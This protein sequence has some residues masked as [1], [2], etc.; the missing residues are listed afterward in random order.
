MNARALVSWACLHV[1]TSPQYSFG[2]GAG[3]G[4]P[5]RPLHPITNNLL[6][7]MFED[8]AEEVTSAGVI[9]FCLLRAALNL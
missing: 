4:R 7:K 2:P 3:A 5:V 9:F 1:L 6:G 8:V